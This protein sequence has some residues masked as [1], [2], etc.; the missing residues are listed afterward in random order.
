VGFGATGSQGQFNFAA[1]RISLAEAVAKA[2]GLND[3]SAEPAYVF[4]YRGVTRDVAEQLGIDISKYPGP[5]IPVIFNVNFRDPAGYFLATRFQMQNKD[6]LYISNATTVQATKAMNFFTTIVNTANDPITFA[7]NI[8][9]LKNL[10]KG[11]TSGVVTTTN[12]I[13]TP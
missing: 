13:T 2:G 5:I 7:T 6:V 3:A 8:Y 12:A 4:L 10:I 1:W 9:G 11:T